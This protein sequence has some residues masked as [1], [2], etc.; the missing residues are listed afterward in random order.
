MKVLIEN[1]ISIGDI[2]NWIYAAIGAFV[3]YIVLHRM[4]NNR[5]RH[6]M[7]KEIEDTINDL[8]MREEAKS[9][10]L[11]N[12]FKCQTV[13]YRTILHDESA[14]D[15]F[16]K[17]NISIDGNQRFVR[18]RNTDQHIELVGTTLLHET[19]IIFRRMQKL[20]VDKI[21][22]DEDLKDLWR[23]IIPFMRA[24]KIEFFIS[25]FGED[26]VKPIISICLHCIYASLKSHHES[27]TKYIANMKSED[28]D[29][30]RYIRKSSNVKF[31]KKKVILKL[32]NASD[33]NRYIDV[34]AEASETNII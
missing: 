20:Y 5:E 28:V 24:G 12:D 14:W 19:L 23:E 8:L 7:V 22:K 1:L 18:I 32:L 30:E 25:Y 10:N 16:K 17:E 11:N 3:A 33:V 27:A 4:Q 13:M 2:I 29:F 6:S 21:I 15:M 26:D 9:S 31:L 34:I